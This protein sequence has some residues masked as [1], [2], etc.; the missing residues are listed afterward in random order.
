M[1]P[2]I[3]QALQQEVNRYNLVQQQ[4]QL[5]QRRIDRYK[6]KCSEIL[7]QR[8]MDVPHDSD[9]HKECTFLMNALNNGWLV[10]DL[11]ALKNYYESVQKAPQGEYKKEGESY[12]YI[13]ATYKVDKLSDRLTMLYNVNNNMYNIKMT[14]S[15]DPAYT[16]AFNITNDLLYNHAVYPVE[17]PDDPDFAY[18]A[19][20]DDL[21]DGVTYGEISNK[22][23]DHYYEAQ[24]ALR[25]TS[26]Y[27][28]IPEDEHPWNTEFAERFENGWWHQ[29]LGG[30]TKKTSSSIKQALGSD[31]YDEIYEMGRGK[32]EDRKVKLHHSLGT[33]FQ[34]QGHE[35]LE[36]EFAGTRGEDVVR[37]HKDRH[38]GIS[39][40]NMSPDGIREKYGT[41][42][43]KP[44]KTNEVFDYIRKKERTINVAGEPVEK[45]RYT[46]GGPPVLN[47]GEYSVQNS[48][49]NAAR[50]TAEFLKTRFEEWIKGK[51]PTPIHIELSGHSR[52]AVTAGQAVIK[53][54][55]WISKYIDEHPQAANFKD[56]INYDLILRD[57][58]PGLG[59]NRTIGDCDLRKIKNVNCTVI[60][61]LGIQGPDDVF[62]LQHVRGS[63]K[64]ILNTMEHQ[65]DISET[66]ESQKNL[67]GND[68]EG[69][70]VSYYDSETGEMHRG[71]GMSELP[72]GIYVADEKYRLVRVTSYSQVN[73]LYNAAFDNGTPQAIRTR[74]I[75]KMCRD[76]FCENELQMSF[77][78]E[79]TRKAE[80]AKA[81]GIKDK[82]L[83][84]NIK[85]LRGVKEELRMV[86]HIKSQP[87]IP[88]EAIIEANKILIK[89]CRDYMKDT[90]MPA[91]GVSAEKLGMVGDMLSF[92]MKENN[93]ISKELNLVPDNDPR[94]ELDEKIR[95]QKERLEKRPGYLEN[96][97]H[98][99]KERLEKEK[100]V[101][102]IVTNTQASCKEYLDNMNRLHTWKKKD[103]SL[104]AI[105][106]EGSRLGPKTSVREMKD[107]LKR[108]TTIAK[109]QEY[110]SLVAAGKRAAFKLNQLSFNLGEPDVPI[111]VRV[112]NREN[113]IKYLK[114]K[115][116]EL[117]N[118]AAP[119]QQEPVQE[120]GKKQ[121]PQ[122]GVV[123]I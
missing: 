108:F 21:S 34:K 83:S 39:T 17:Y 18:V 79:K 94:K 82:L 3:E 14:N 57:P 121:K 25:R 120:A 76:W 40:K 98:W 60:A 36:L 61:S 63:K 55:E 24:Q 48:R 65:M 73:E 59:T 44:G 66:D 27:Y 87:N 49:D 32:A 89:A 53:I 115:E 71:T 51:A 122:S 47:F 90:K 116:Q 13:M 104:K 41:P 62:P 30:I 2:E 56:F 38:G 4:K 110:P 91:K 95:L 85:R 58:V 19:G 105:L 31:I 52:G 7:G 20:K 46:F 96:K 103:A 15:K 114:N 10:S 9:D 113:N 101:Y 107:F 12:L 64:L 117:I 11:P 28:Y 77:P 109:K 78:D 26:E 67:F 102:S 99:E 33:K 93:Q 6:R 35:V 22:S 42:V 118:E 68:K 70:M 112:Q 74:R 81:A 97:Q 54:D 5:N 8:M 23:S 92:A 119:K 88:K 84:M 45:V 111:G 43:P 72:D 1:D 69:H 75:Q 29:N 37:T 50:L 16:N 100:E 106:E 123:A 86:D 80:E